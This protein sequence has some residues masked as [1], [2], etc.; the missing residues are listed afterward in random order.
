MGV[1]SFNEKSA[2]G[3]L[4]SG[5]PPAQSPSPQSPRPF[6]TKELDYEYASQNAQNRQFRQINNS[7]ERCR[8][9]GCVIFII[10]AATTC[11]IL[12]ACALSV[13][14]YLHRHRGQPSISKDNFQ[15]AAADPHQWI[16]VSFLS[17]LSHI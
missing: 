8:K 14:F 13:G 2:P 4:E 9:Y 12:F 7:H 15:S 11:A 3:Q 16:A 17:L 5:L 1:P 6:I 10:I